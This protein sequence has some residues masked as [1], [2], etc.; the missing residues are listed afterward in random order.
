MAALVTTGNHDTYP[1]SHW[2]DMGLGLEGG[3]EEEDFTHEEKA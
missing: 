2:R 3:A 1:V